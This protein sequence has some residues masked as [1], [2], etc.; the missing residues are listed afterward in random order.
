MVAPEV[1][2]LVGVVQ[3]QTPFGKPPPIARSKMTEKLWSIAACQVDV[4]TWLSLTWKNWVPSR[5]QVIDSAAVLVRFTM[6]V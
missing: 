5:Y 3:P 1:V 2:E 6:T 4:G